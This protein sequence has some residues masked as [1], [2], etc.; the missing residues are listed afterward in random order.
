MDTIFALATAR[1]RAGVAVIRIS[2]DQATAA[3]SRL[4]TDVP[5]VRGI[6]SITDPDGNLLDQALVLSF[7]KGKSFTGEEVVEL[8]LHGSPA[9]VAAVLRELGEDG[10]LTPAEAGEFTRRALENGQLD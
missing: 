3:A 9:V 10:D 4:M 7:P 5:A 6:R 8:H 2:G 1:G